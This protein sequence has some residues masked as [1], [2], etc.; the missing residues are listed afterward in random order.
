MNVRVL[1][2]CLWVGC[3][4]GLY[5]LVSAH[6]PVLLTIS[7]DT[8]SME[9]NIHGGDISFIDPTVT[10]DDIDESDVVVYESDEIRPGDFIGHR[11]IVNSSTDGLVTKGDNERFTDQHPSVG[12]PQVTDDNLEGRVWYTVETSRLLNLLPY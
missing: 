12:E 1:N 4:I 2:R 6:A 7:A 9:P 8:G 10:I 3:L 11:V 5:I